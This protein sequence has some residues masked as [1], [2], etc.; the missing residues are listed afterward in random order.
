MS[1][2]VKVPVSSKAEGLEPA[3][4]EGGSSVPG[5]LSESRMSD[6]PGPCVSLTSRR[7]T[8][9]TSTHSS[10]KTTREDDPTPGGAVGGGTCQG[11]P[12][13]ESS[14]ASKV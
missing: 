12:A 1:G 13:T 8:T 9:T 5:E 3:E 10:N 6:R 2:P 11:A 14:P 4:S 7:Q